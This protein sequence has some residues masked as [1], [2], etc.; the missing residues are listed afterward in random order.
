MAIRISSKVAIYIKF[1]LNIILN[2]NLRLNILNFFNTLNSNCNICPIAKLE[3]R[4]FDYIEYLLITDFFHTRT[5]MECVGSQTVPQARF[6]H[7]SLIIQLEE[8]N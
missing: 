6:S 8:F 3:K 2:I 5:V 1:I 7:P 4:A